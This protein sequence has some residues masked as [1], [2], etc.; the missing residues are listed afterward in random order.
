MENTILIP[1]K[2]YKDPTFS[3]VFYNNIFMSLIDGS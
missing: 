3:S 1:R 2:Y